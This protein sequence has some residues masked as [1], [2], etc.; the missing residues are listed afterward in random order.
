MESHTFDPLDVATAATR[1][2]S[3]D[4][5]PSAGSPP[6]SASPTRPSPAATAGCSPRAGCG[7]SP[8]ATAGTLGQ[9]SW[10]LR[11]RCA[12]DGAETIANAARAPPRHRLDRSHLGRHR[13][14]LHDPRRVPRATR[15][16]CCSASS[17]G[18]RSIVEIRAFQLLHR[19]FGGPVGW[20]VKHGPLTGEQVAALRPAPVSP[21]PGPPGS[22]PRTSRWSPPSNATAVPPS[23]SSSGPPGG[24]SPPSS[25]GSANCSAP[26]RC[27]STSS[28][29]PGWSGSPSGPSC[30]S[31]RRRRRWTPWGARW[32]THARSRSRRRRPV[33]RNLV[34]TVVARD[35]AALYALPEWEARAA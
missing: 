2:R 25:G 30:G 28:T 4:A 19:F 26:A 9:D 18:R 6:S 14:R 12:P 10:I 7:S 35:T 15:T 27:S 22:P 23:P 32:P 5:P 21:M 1:W 24:P 8:Y 29:T 33:R 34:A 16:T 13:G 20:L 17:R 31:R 11:L 3:T